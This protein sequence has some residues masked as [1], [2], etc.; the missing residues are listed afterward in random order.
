[1]R[2][3]ARTAACSQGG[4]GRSRQGPGPDKLEAAALCPS[5][6]H[7]WAQD[8]PRLRLPVT[9]ARERGSGSHILGPWRVFVAERSSPWHT[10]GQ[11]GRWVLLL[12]WGASGL[13]SPALDS[14]L[15]TALFPFSA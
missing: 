2:T 13:S 3:E 5:A 15:G 4:P 6:P 9:L 10:A 14:P 12:P 8:V 11:M 7:L 1:M